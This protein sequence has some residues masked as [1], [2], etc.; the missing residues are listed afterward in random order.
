MK[1]M[2]T[3]PRCNKNAAYDGFELCEECMNNMLL[4][5]SDYKFIPDDNFFKEINADKPKG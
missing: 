5:G 4:G 2:N 3:C 1:C